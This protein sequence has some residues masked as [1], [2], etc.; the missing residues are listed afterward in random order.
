MSGSEEHT[1]SGL[2]PAA[3]PGEAPEIQTSP[4]RL[5]WVDRFRNL[6]GRK[7]PQAMALDIPDVGQVEVKQPARKISHPRIPTSQR[8]TV[9]NLRQQID[10]AGGLDAL[11]KKR[12]QREGK[13][14]PLDD[15][16]A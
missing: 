16:R 14:P 5:S 2:P 12:R 1:G 7:K 8:P 13:P 15:P 4:R 3:P 9:P 10:A 11:I 6:M